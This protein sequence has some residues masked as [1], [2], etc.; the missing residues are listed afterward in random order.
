MAYEKCESARDNFG[1]FIYQFQSKIKTLTRKLERILI[2]SYRQNMSSLINQ[3]CI[4]THTHTHTHTHI[5]IYIYIYINIYIYIYKLYLQKKTI[6]RACACEAKF[7]YLPLSH[8]L[9]IRLRTKILIN[10][11]FSNILYI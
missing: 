7:V 11:L 4:H 1:K 8:V 3:T 9:T 6:A 5:Y 10:K 2:K